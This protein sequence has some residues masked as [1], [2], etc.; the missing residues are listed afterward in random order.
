MVVGRRREKSEDAVSLGLSKSCSLGSDTSVSC[1]NPSSVTGDLGA[2]AIVF[3][4]CADR[5]D[6]LGGR[7]CCFSICAEI[8][9]KNADPSAH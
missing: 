4:S 9:D 6:S 3:V 7:S 5:V 2:S 1:V 8:K